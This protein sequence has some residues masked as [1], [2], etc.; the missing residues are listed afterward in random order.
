MGN[1]A[2]GS[3]AVP[4][5]GYAAF[6][7]ADL[8]EVRSRLIANYTLPPSQNL[9]RAMIAAHA[10]GGTQQFADPGVRDPA[11]QADLLIRNEVARLRAA[12]LFWV[13]PDMTALCRAAAPAMPA[14]RPGR[15][16]LPADC[17]LMYFASPFSTYEALPRLFIY[18]EGTAGMMIAEEQ[19]PVCAVAW[20]PWNERGDWPGGGT[21]FS[22]Y[23]PAPPGPPEI[24]GRYGVSLEAAA[25]IRMPPLLLDNEV[26]CP[27]SESVRLGR[28]L[29]DSVRDPQSLYSLMHVVL[30]ACRLMAATR[31]TAVA[32]AELPARHVRR[33]AARAGVASPDDP[34]R[35]VDLRA[36]PARR[37]AADGTAERARAGPRVRFP[38]RGHWRNQWYPRAQANRPIWIEEFIKGPDG[39]PFRARRTVYL[40]RQPG[41][42]T[43]PPRPPDPGPELE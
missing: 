32:D 27:A 1:G 36:R 11:A 31:T 22:F 37:A 16:D 35:L 7:A 13:S 19:V 9:V 29:E 17:G 21:W 26:T 4:P 42:P 33:R 3:G 23:S 8:P 30:C 39:A 43:S 18:E 41:E 24:A 28:P 34:V 40:L 12:T 14:F 5:A 6:A 10:L 2:P 38:V 25:R 15:D 20:G